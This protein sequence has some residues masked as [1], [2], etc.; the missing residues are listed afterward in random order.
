[1]GAAFVPSYAGLFLG[2]WE[3]SDS[4]DDVPEEIMSEEEDHISKMESNVENSD[5]EVEYEEE[6]DT[7]TTSRM[8]EIPSKNKCVIWNLQPSQATPGPTSFVRVVT[9]VWDNHFGGR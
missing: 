8:Q 7:Q 5:S 3:T 1:M 4:E 2:L 6:H 9:D